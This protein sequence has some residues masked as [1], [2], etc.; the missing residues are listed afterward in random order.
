MRVG[1]AVAVAVGTLA[2]ALGAVACNDDVPSTSS[3]NPPGSRA[4]AA[5]PPAGAPAGAAPA[6]SRSAVAG[7][8]SS[9]S[10]APAAGGSAE[11]V[12][13]T[14]CHTGELKADVQLQPDFPGTAMVMLTN[15]GTRT[16]T[17]Y[18]YLG[19]GGL[20]ADN[21]PVTLGTSRV[22]HPGPP[23]EATLKPGTTAF[24]G[25]KWASCDKGDVSCHVLA[26]VTITPPDETTQL[27]ANV[28]DANGKP[29]E[30][31]TVSAAGFTVGS[32][33]PSNQGVIFAS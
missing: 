16:C 3:A 23:V 17:V 21:S 12:S 28:L 30:Q 25:L 5:A 15:K 19:Y 14:R 7:A 26:G 32:L 31:L 33:Q 22:A 1:K 24:S 20:L 29:L 9:R 13:S 27:T 2:L 10:V 18:G 4:P 11:P 8:A 6:A